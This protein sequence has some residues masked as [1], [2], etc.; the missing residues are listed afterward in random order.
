[1]IW[2][3]CVGDFAFLGQ[4][5]LEG[6]AGSGG[7]GISNELRHRTI[8]Q[9]GF[10]SQVDSCQQSGVVLL[11]ANHG[12]FGFV[13]D[14]QNDTQFGIVLCIGLSN[15]SF[16]ESTVQLAADDFSNDIGNLAQFNNV[17]LSA[18]INQN[19]KSSVS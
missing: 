17:S 2:G 15:D 6:I 10:D 16:D 3:L 8:F 7:I 9:S 5:T 11:N 4:Q 14:R 13:G 12:A 1:M 19:S 18:D